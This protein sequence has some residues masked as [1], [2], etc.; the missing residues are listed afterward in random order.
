MS[1][2]AKTKALLLPLCLVGLVGCQ[3]AP[4]RDP[5]FSVVRPSAM[6]PLESRNGAIYQ[7]GYSAPLFEDQRARLVGDMLTIIL[8]ESTDASKT[9]ET[10]FTK[11]NTTT[12]TNPTI[13]GSS[14]EFDLPGV[15]PLAS[16]KKNNLSSSLSSNHAFDGEAE[17]VQS[18]ALTGEITVTVA[19]V[20][21]N[22]NL[23]V[24]GEKILTLNQGH[25][26][27]R[28]SGIVRAADIDANNSVASPRVANA[29]IIYAGE[30]ALADSNAVGWLAKFFIGALMPF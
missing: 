1:Y 7:A 5:A 18:N 4:T 19:E 21:P 13:L 22:G 11:T 2:L 28:F 25:E 29:R 30:G 10:D 20:L 27:I 24:Q 23:V 15:V 12:V 17:S 26:H 6:P 8:N 3:S 14:P 9:A 16:T